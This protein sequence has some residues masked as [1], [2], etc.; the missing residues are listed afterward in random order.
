MDQLLAQGAQA[1]LQYLEQQLELDPAASAQLVEYLATTKAV[2]GV[3]PSQKTIVFE[4]FF[5]ET[6][7]MHFVIHAPFGSRVNKA[8][9]LALRKRFCRRFNFELQAAANEDNLILSLGPTHSFPLEE[10]SRYLAADTVEHVLIQALLDAPMF[11]TRWRWVT[12]IS[13]AVPRMRG[14]KRVPAPFQRNDAEDLVALVFPDQLACFENI[15]GE[16]EVPDHPLVSQVL[17]DCLHELMDIDGLKQILVAIEQ[18]HIQIISKDLPTPSPMAHEILNARPYAFLDDTPAEERRALAVQ[19]RRHMDPHTAADMGRLNPDAIEKVKQQAW[20]QPRSADELHDALVITGFIAESEINTKELESW[21]HYLAQLQQG[22]RATRLQQPSGETLWVAA[23]RL[24]ALQLICPEGKTAPA[25]MPLPSAEAESIATALTEIIRSRLESLGPVTVVELAQPIGRATREVQQALLQLEQEGFVIQGRFDPQRTDTEWCERGLLA[26]I[27]RY[28]LKQLRSE[29]EPVS[30]ADFMR[31]LFNWQG[32]DEPAEGIAALERVLQQLEGVSLPA[33]SWEQDILPARLQPYFST[34]LDELC[35]SGKL[36]WLRLNP[37][38]SKD[39][40]RRNPAIK[41]TPLA[42]IFRPHLMFWYQPQQAITDD[43]SSSALKVLEVLKQWGASFFD[44][45]QQQTGL[46]KTQLE[47]TLGELVAR[48]LINADHFQGLR[49][50]ITPQKKQSRSRRRPALHTPLAAGGRWSLVRSPLLDNNDQQRI[51][52]IVRTLLTRYGVVFRKLLERES[53]LPSWRDLLYVLRRLEARGEIRGG[54]FVQ[55]FAGEQFALPEAVSLLRSVRKQQHDEQ[56][57][58]IST[59]DPLNLT[60]IIT[61]GKRIAA[62]AGHRIMYKNG[63]PVATNISGDIQ[64]DN[65]IPASEHWQIKSL[66]TRKH[67]PEAFHK[68]PQGPLI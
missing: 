45:L 23:E 3:I 32:L 35:S 40:K 21:Q 65:S 46:L 17:W 44:E 19:Q 5:D 8:W 34:E 37:P 38:T 58:T 9:G 4:R 7:D 10:P 56:L 16:R 39:H 22:Q 6:G 57:I 48:G 24:Q 64:I 36:T 52:Q 47:T 59:A 29:I 41:T 55:G 61:P 49:A 33:G 30:P 12:N 15:Q 1:A 2:F 27:H 26:R 28:T 62:Q 50:L 53:M 54:R 31:F 18:Q 60:G 51:E 14:G 63:K 67:R 11:P 68:P 20:P 43:L 25:I 42:F 13:L 66:L